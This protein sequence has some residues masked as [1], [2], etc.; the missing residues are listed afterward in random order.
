MDLDEYS[1]THLLAF[2]DARAP[3]GRLIQ[4]MAWWCRKYNRP[5]KDPLL[6]TYT[7]DELSYEYFLDMEIQR[8]AEENVQLEADK[9]EEAKQKNAEAWADEM[10]EEDEEGVSG[11]AAEWMAKELEKSKTLLGD[12]NFGEN[13]DIEF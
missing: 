1:S 5:F 7:I 3:S 11:E 13:L 9:I 12:N 4:L 6:Q 2:R 10:E 8:A